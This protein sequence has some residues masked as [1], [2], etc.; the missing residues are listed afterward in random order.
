MTFRLWRCF[1]SEILRKYR[2]WIM[3]FSK[4]FFAQ[5]P[6]LLGP[7]H[8]STS[9]FQNCFATWNNI[10]GIVVCVKRSSTIWS[11]KI[12][13]MHVEAQPSKI[14]IKVI[15][16]SSKK[17]PKI[18]SSQKLRRCNIPAKLS[19]IKVSEYT[20]LEKYNCGNTVP[21]KGHFWK[22]W[23]QKNTCRHLSDFCCCWKYG[24]CVRPKKRCT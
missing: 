20:A 8:L 3:S 12:E 2:F 1:N 15:K 19:V 17:K 7:K 6:V 16:L 11:A 18:T 21:E 9:P 5:A 14:R 23:F 4:Y 10:P 13:N 24:V 22:I